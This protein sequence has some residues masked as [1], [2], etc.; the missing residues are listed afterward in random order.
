MLLWL[1]VDPQFR[2][3]RKQ[4]SLAKMTYFP[5]ID[6][7]YTVQSPTQS[8]AQQNCPINLGWSFIFVRLSNS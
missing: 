3:L 7:L 6:V 8:S 5:D 2:D 1:Y 4:G